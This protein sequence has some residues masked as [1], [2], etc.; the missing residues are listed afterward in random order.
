MPKPEEAG[1]IIE[2]V[3]EGE[4]V[5]C[6]SGATVRVNYR[7]RLTDGTEFDSNWFEEPIEFALADLIEAWRLGIPGM[8]I[9]GVRRLTVPPALG[10][11]ERGA[12]PTIP[13]NATLV[14]D[15]RLVGIAKGRR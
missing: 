4:G 11:G 1:L 6:Q 14:F 8:R 2:D 7:G 10:Y 9:G 5:E 15:I 3:E 13:P 12:P